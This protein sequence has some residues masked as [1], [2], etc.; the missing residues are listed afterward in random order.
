MFTH[1]LYHQQFPEFTESEEWKAVID[2]TN[3]WFLQPFFEK[4]KA[5]GFGDRFLAPHFR[6]AINQAIVSDIRGEMDEPSDIVEFVPWAFQNLPSDCAVL[7]LLVNQFCEDWLH[8]IDGEED[9]VAL[10]TLPIEFCVRV[11]RRSTEV[12]RLKH[13]KHQDACYLEHVSDDSA[14]ACG[15]AHV[16]YDPGHDYGYL[17]SS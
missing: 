13:V 12:R 6:R 4:V 5:H 8:T 11:M 10:K 15:K 16:R 9:V 14:K 7:Q 3:C 1:W 2:P 17:K